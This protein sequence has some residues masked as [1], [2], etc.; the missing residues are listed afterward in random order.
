MGV[1]TL[2]FTLNEE[3]NLPSCL[4]SLRWCDDVIVVDSFSSDSTEEIAR[5][6]GVRFFQHEFTGFGDQRNWAVDHCH[7]RH[8]W[9]L[10]LDADER[11]GPELAQELVQ[12]TKTAPSDIGGYRIRRRLIF[13][14]RW[15]RHSSLYP[16]WV[17]R[18]VRRDRARYR[19]R[20]HAETQEIAGR[21]LACSNDLIDE[22]KK[23]IE[24]WFGRQNV[25]SSREAVYEH[26][27]NVG[28]ARA[29]AD[30]LRRDGV[31]R[32]QGLKQL[33]SK[34]PLR[35]LWYFMYSYFFRLGFLDG[36]PGFYFCRMRAMY[37]S[38]IEIK[39]FDLRQRGLLEDDEGA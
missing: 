12:I 37:Q 33:S 30:V 19:N 23:G 34:L 7:P 35:G 6:F 20:G 11:V 17:V 21:V 8:P 27:R 28:I 15:L 22:D 18:F 9:L 5:S 13:W 25:Y 36:V 24:S 38:Q 31:V 32:R 3:V 26:G 39:R 1:S 2:V 29:L 10:F 16:T 4:E 14:G